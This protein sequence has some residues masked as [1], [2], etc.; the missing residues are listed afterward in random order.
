MA[1]T[2][3]LL[4][5][6][7]LGN[8]HGEIWDLV[9]DYAYSSII[10]MH[11]L[12]LV[13]KFFAANFNKGNLVTKVVRRNFVALLKQ[14]IRPACAP[15][16]EEDLLGS[17]F[18][19]FL[20]GLGVS[21]VVSGGFALATL[22]R[23]D[24]ESDPWL[25]TDMNILISDDMVSSVEFEAA[26]SSWLRDMRHLLQ[27]DDQTVYQQGSHRFSC[28]VPNITERLISGTVSWVFWGTTA[29][30]RIQFIF[31][32]ADEMSPAVYVRDWVDFT[33]LMNTITIA[34][35]WRLPRVNLLHPND[36]LT[37]AGRYSQDFLEDWVSQW[38]RWNRAKLHRNFRGLIASY[39]DSKIRVKWLKDRRFKYEARGF[40]F[41]SL[42]PKGKFYY[43]RTP[44]LKCQ[45]SG[46]RLHNVRKR[47]LEHE[48][49]S[50]QNDAQY[51]TVDDG[52]A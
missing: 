48:D 44:F 13:S 52:L 32:T 23:A 29:H 42:I 4:S 40:V 10:D 30:R 27:E 49:A 28:W 25:M 37:K 5:V 18:C 17:L 16:R 19:N 51:H 1:T 15:D 8:A 41:K 22:L 24:L 45:Q 11:N 12:K 21:Y 7:A 31:L 26:F 39:R 33:F 46:D 2:P 35:N 50:Q 14:F 36:V 9:V 38:T 3:T 6:L 43:G 20:P 47:K 34:T